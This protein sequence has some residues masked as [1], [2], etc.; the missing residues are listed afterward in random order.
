MCSCCPL[1]CCPRNGDVAWEAL[2]STSALR[3]LGWDY[4]TLSHSLVNITPPAADDERGG[5]R[6]GAGRGGPTANG[7]AAA[8]GGGGSGVPNGVL[9]M[10][11]DMEDM[12]RRAS[13]GL[14]FRAGSRLG[15]RV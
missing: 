3:Q 15:L 14:G 2:A 12:V 10:K 7:A 13:E 8:A 4:D 1:C 9:D 6:G 11:G 5:G